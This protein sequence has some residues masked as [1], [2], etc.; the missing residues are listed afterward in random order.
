MNKEQRAISKEQSKGV[1]D[2]LSY[3]V[4]CSLLIALFL[5]PALFIQAQTE[6]SRFVHR[7]TW[8][9]DASAI[10]YEVVIEREDAGVYREM[11]REFTDLSYVEYSFSPGRYR[12]RVI[13]Y[14]FLFRAASPS[15][16]MNFEVRPALIPELDPAMP[17]YL[18]LDDDATHALDISGRNLH[19]DAEIVLRHS[20]GASIVPNNKVIHPEGSNAWLFFNNDQLTP[21]EYEVHIKNPGG[22]ETRGRTII[23]IQPEPIPEPIIVQIEEPEPEPVVVIE[24]PAP[25][26]VVEPSILYKFLSLAWMPL[27]PLYG[28]EGRFFDQGS[29]PAGAA[30]RLG[31]R[32]GPRT[33]SLGTEL[34]FSWYALNA[35]SELA[36]FTALELNLLVQGWFPNGKTALI[37]R[38]GAGYTL[39]L[40]D[41]QGNF[42]SSDYSSIH[43]NIGVSFFWLITKNLYFETG[44]DYTHWFTEAPS[45]AFRPWIGLG[46][47]F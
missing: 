23:V 21:G 24:E 46:W 18:Y 27:S 7:L 34:A 30:I 11:Y 4:H 29:S 41:D 26:K 35:D 33:I 47:R 13:P 37:F 6:P 28:E 19:P 1:Q 17:V 43:T 38:A 9:R 8:T 42:N 20:G 16:W 3:F 12:F 45:G 15:A 22:F 25:V 10:H 14:D 44:L 32:S 31:V 40:F 2:N 5:L 36:H 39:L